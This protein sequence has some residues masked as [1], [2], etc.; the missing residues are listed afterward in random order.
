MCFGISH[1]V[2]VVLGNVAFGVGKVAHSFEDGLVYLR[3]GPFR[4]L[5]ACFSAKAAEAILTHTKNIAKAVEYDFVVPW[6]GDGL[7]LR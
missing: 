1:Y 6:L 5:V 3:I 4:H 2:L 7:L